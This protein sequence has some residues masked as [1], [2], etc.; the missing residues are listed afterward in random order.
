MSRPPQ[1][2][3]GCMCSSCHLSSKLFPRGP[4]DRI[5]LPAIRPSTPGYRDTDPKSPR[6]APP[7]RPQS[8]APQEYPRP[9]RRADAPP[10]PPMP[11]MPQ[12]RGYGSGGGGEPSRSRRSSDVR[13]RT[14]THRPTPSYPSAPAPAPDRYTFAPPDRPATAMARPSHHRS[15]SHQAPPPPQQQEGPP[16]GD[17]SNGGNLEWMPPRLKWVKKKER[18][19][20]FTP[21]SQYQGTSFRQYV[22]DGV[23]PRN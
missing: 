20:H 3:P 23:G 1:H 17:G 7:P 6:F 4:N 5:I 9:H 19:S 13:D 11:P 12:P 10:V 8:T 15:Q 22:H 2:A 18:V 21:P 16:Q 14:P